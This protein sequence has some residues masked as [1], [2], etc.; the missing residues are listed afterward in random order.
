MPERKKRDI[1][2][3]F[4]GLKNFL[5]VHVNI[6]RNPLL[7]SC[8]KNLSPENKSVKIELETGSEHIK[9]CNIPL[10]VF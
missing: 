4:D 2:L 8:N 1:D 3:H 7:L 10:T 5:S 9:N 6:Q